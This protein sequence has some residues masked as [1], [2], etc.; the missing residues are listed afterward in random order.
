MRCSIFAGV[1]SEKRKKAVAVSEKEIQERS[2]EADF[3][4]AVFLARKCPNLG[5]RRNLPETLPARH[6]GQPHPA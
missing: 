4:T 1:D 2:R 3:P 6:F 5:R